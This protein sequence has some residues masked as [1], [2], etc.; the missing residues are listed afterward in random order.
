[1]EEEAS[2]SCDTA[3][4][5]EPSITELRDLRN[6]LQSRAFTYSEL[7]DGR[8]ASSAATLPSNAPPS[9]MPSNMA[10]SLREDTLQQQDDATKFAIGTRSRRRISDEDTPRG[11]TLPIRAFSAGI[12]SD[13]YNTNWNI[14]QDFLLVHAG[15]NM[16]QESLRNECWIEP[17]W[18]EDMTSSLPMTPDSGVSSRPPTRDLSS[19]EGR[20][21]RLELADNETTKNICKPQPSSSNPDHSRRPPNLPFGSL[22]AEKKAKR[23]ANKQPS[24]KLRKFKVVRGASKPMKDYE[25]LIFPPQPPST[26]SPSRG[27][28]WEQNERSLSA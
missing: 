18:V 16:I 10:F 19:I 5:A 14:N 20:L 11:N 3:T 8:A 15:D 24:S 23:T 27:A 6:S 7:D 13:R 2:A 21:S 9:P 4:P 12:S 22:D 17:S 1:M 26:Q 28:Y 25:K